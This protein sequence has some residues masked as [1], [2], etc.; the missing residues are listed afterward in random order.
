[1]LAEARQCSVALPPRVKTG[2][3]A[4]NHVLA[5]SSDRELGQELF[6]GLSS[7]SLGGLNGFIKDR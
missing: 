3:R 2:C 7:R 6:E 1:M 5:R 4:M